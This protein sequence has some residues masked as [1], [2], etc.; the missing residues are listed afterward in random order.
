M[1]RSLE[2]KI[3]I[4]IVFIYCI[5]ALICCGMLFYIYKFSNGVK[6]QKDRIEANNIILSLTN[7]LIYS[8]Q[9]AQASTS[10]YVST[11]NRNY[12]SSFQE[13]YYNIDQVIDSLLLL[14]GNQLQREKLIEIGLLLDKSKMIIHQLNKEFVKSNPFDTIYQTI[15]DYQLE[16]HTDSLLFITVRQDTTIQSAPKKNFWDRLA[17]LFAPKKNIDTL[18]TIT[19]LVSDTLKIP[20][21]DT[22]G[23]LSDIQTV[24]EYANKTY[25]TQITKIQRQVNNLILSDRQISEEIFNLLLNLHRETINSVLYEI[26]ASE[27][28]IKKNYKFL[29]I[30][31]ILSLVLILVFILLIINDV[32]KGR[33]A[34]KALEE[35]NELTKRLMEERHKLL[36]SV[37]HDIK[38]PLTSIL[39][40]ADLWQQDTSLSKKLSGIFSIQNSGN[41]ILSMLE[42]LLE[43]SKLEQGTLEIHQTNFHLESLYNE[44]KEMFIP[45]VNKKQLEFDCEFC[46]EKT[47]WLHSDRL[48]IKQIIANILSNA[49]K[50]TQKGK[51][52]F[53]VDYRNNRLCFIITDTGVGIPEK[54]LDKLFKPFSRI[55]KN[56]VLAKGN[57]FG[58]YLVKGLVDLLQG[59]IIIQSKEGEGTNV[60]IKIPVK[61]V[62]VGNVNAPENIPLSNYLPNKKYKLLVID[63]DN[64]L[65][66]MLQEMI[67]RLG[68]EITVCSSLIEFE[69]QLSDIS[70][71]DF[72]LTDMEMGSFSGLDILQKIKEK[73][74]QIP[75]IIMTARSDFD[76]TQALNQGFDGY[77]PKPFSLK[78]LQELLASEHEETNNNFSSNKTDKDF[79]SLYEMLDGDKEAVKNILKV[80]V[81]TTSENTVLLQQCINEDDFITAQSICHKMLPM[82]SQL[83]TVE[84]VVI[85][86]K[87]DSMRGKNSNEYSFW[88]EDLEEL[89]RLSDVLIEFIKEEYFTD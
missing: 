62:T 27:Q 3:R 68:Y 79:K 46:P 86:K 17:N 18:L 36:L 28:I 74:T 38:A 41:Y 76:I 13:A 59:V 64:S 22:S 29:L 39:G 9:Q 19:T 61:T 23:I 51:I 48:K 33:A 77:L 21:E 26:E 40:Y 55:E 16:K 45:L 67:I 57:G 88:K 82:F 7:N 5:I 20:Q 15:M 72:I 63:D 66:S 34:R 35:A 14:S 78:S 31:G 81:N 10:L 8:V 58:L 54:E 80:F 73:N 6:E 1:K 4:N 43:F 47:L 24:S 69:K 75:V 89:I 50:Y 71:Y 30:G 42:N 32:N 25:T 49:I 85:L 70:H 56:I 65:L 52:T 2:N 60:T 87:M 83:E 84:A 11:Q 12:I 53:L 37:S 44:V